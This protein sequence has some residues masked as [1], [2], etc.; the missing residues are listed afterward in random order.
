MKFYCKAYGKSVLHKNNY[1]DGNLVDFNAPRMSKED[2]IKT[3]CDSC[4]SCNSCNSGIPNADKNLSNEDNIL[5]IDI[6]FVDV[7][8]ILPD[9]T[10]FKLFD[11]YKFKWRKKYSQD[12]SKK[13]FFQSIILNIE[14]TNIVGFFFDN[15]DDL[16]NLDIYNSTF[17]ISINDHGEIIKYGNVDVYPVI[18]N[19]EKMTNS[20]FIYLDDFDGLDIENIFYR[21]KAISQVVTD[22]FFG[23]KNETY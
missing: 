12:L 9:D 4:N 16:N 14:N 23:D 10:S 15:R 13:L 3:Y 18:N 6:N 5:F 1:G 20:Y 19:N 7:N 8:D 2:F 21:L 11:C 17:N 22:R